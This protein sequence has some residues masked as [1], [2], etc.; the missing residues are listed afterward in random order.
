MVDSRQGIYLLVSNFVVHYFTALTREISSK[1]KSRRDISCLR[2]PSIIKPLFIC[3][4]LANLDV[5]NN[6]IEPIIP[7]TFTKTK[8][9]Y[10]SMFTSYV[11]YDKAWSELLPLFTK[12]SCISP[13][14]GLHLLAFI[15]GNSHVWHNDPQLKWNMLIHDCLAWLLNNLKVDFPGSAWTCYLFFFSG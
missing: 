12:M 10:K 15:H 6:F 11:Q 1:L 8:K 3:L 2:A 5:H 9:I 13:R 4:F 7:I 14:C